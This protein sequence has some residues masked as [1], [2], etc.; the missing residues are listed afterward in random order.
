MRKHKKTI[1]M[2]A[3]AGILVVMLSTFVV[4][5]GVA[6]P[7]WS[8]NPLILQPGESAT[9][10][11]SLQNMVGDRDLTLR[12][13]LVTGAAIAT[14]LDSDLD[15]EVPAGSNNIPVRIRID[16]PADAELGSEF[17]VSISF[18]EVSDG[19]GGTVKLT[20]KIGKSFRVIA[21]EPEQ[22]I[23][24]APEPEPSFSPLMIAIIIAIAVAVVYFAA[25]KR[26]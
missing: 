1:G 15:Y 22:P 6:A 20:G 10:A 12:A 9:I 2:F 8:E 13:E 21:G 24:E 4:A 17:P 23:I 26:E 3:L 5:F 16:V 14:L 7:Y 25:R 18:T 11:L 19:T